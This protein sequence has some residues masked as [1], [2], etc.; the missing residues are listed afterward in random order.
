MKQTLAR[1]L[2]EMNVIREKIDSD[3]K[4]MKEKMTTNRAK[5]AAWPK[6]TTACRSEGGISRKGEGQPTEDGGRPG[7][8]GGP[9][10]YFRRKIEENEHHG[11]GCQSRKVG[12]LNSA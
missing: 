7:I 9:G 8:N 11:F 5:M 6:G 2:A 12:G 4:E 3:Q 10:K 1:L